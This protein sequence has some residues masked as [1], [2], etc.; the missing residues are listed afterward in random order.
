[1]KKRWRVVAAV[2]LV[3][4]IA[5]SAAVVQGDEVS[6]WAK[7]KALFIDWDDNAPPGSARTE[8]VGVR[9]VGLEK[10]LGD[11][12]FDWSAVNYMED[13]KVSME[14]EKAFLQEAKL[15]PYQEQ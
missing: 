7:F 15:G 4:G 6:Y 8:T 2:A 11:E 1:M 3:I 10:E 9:G 14:M 12:G 5:L 13:L